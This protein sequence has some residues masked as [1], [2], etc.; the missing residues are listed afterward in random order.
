MAWSGFGIFLYGEQDT[1]GSLECF[2]K[3]HK[4]T[5]KFMTAFKDRHVNKLKVV[6]EVHDAQVKTVHVRIGDAKKR[7]LVD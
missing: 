6:I 2:L 4:A 1:F 3:L 5:G 7:K